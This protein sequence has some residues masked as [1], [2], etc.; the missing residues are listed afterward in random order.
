VGLTG[1]AVLGAFVTPGLF[2]GGLAAAGAPILIHLLARR[3]FKRLR[4]AAID[5][6][7]QAERK[8]RRRLRLEEWI[9][10]A[11]RCLAFILI[12]AALA[13]PFLSPDSFS[14]AL[15]GA[16]RA[17]RII[18][19]DDSM[20]MAYRADGKPVFDRAKQ[21]V[22]RLVEG[23]RRESPDDTVSLFKTSS[24]DTPIESGTFLNDAQTETLFARVE[25]LA[26]SQA[27]LDR[28]RVVSGVADFLADSPNI[29][30]AAIYVISDFQRSTWVERDADVKPEAKGAS[31]FELWREWAGDERSLFIT[32]VNVGE[33]EA[34]NSAVTAFE[35]GTGPLVA[36]T[37]SAARLRVANYSQRTLDSL[38]V[39]VFVS[40]VNQQTVALD[41]LE[42]GDEVTAD[43]ELEF[44]R[45]GSE[46]AR[47]EIPEDALTPDNTR[48]LSA[49]VSE[50]IRVLVVDGEPAPDRYDDEVTFL[51]TALRPE[52]ALASGNAPVVMDETEWEDAE[53]HEFHVVVLANVHR[54]SEPMVEQLERFVREGGGLLIFAG[55][56]TNSDLYN[57]AL[58]REGEG[59]LPVTLTEVKRPAEP[60]R[61]VVTDRLH[62][63]LRAL[64]GDGDP[65]G[66]GN[67]RFRAF[68][69]VHV[70]DGAEDAA[71]PGAVPTVDRSLSAP[72]R[73]IARF[74]DG[75]KSPAIIERR[76]GAGRVIFV[77]TSADK[78]WNDWPDHPTYLPVVMELT[79]Y[80]ARGTDS[81]D[82][83]HVGDAIQ[84]PLDPSVFESDVTVRTPSWPDEREI[85]VTPIAPKDGSDL[86]VQWDRTPDPGL[87]RFVFA[88]RDGGEEVCA[89]A[90]NVDE[91]ESD[92]AMASED[93]LSGTVGD[94]PFRYVEGLAMLSA[95]G[96]CERR[97][98]LW[99]FFLI[100][101]FIALWSEHTLAWAWG[102]R[103][104]VPAVDV[105][106][107]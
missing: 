38:S 47:I 76:L 8:N 37:P 100:A 15:R 66:V 87:Y 85:V 50:S 10:L 20:S 61:L 92:L 90:V 21:A 104:D 29:I 58:Y 89:A 97:T 98:E 28:G 102:R 11:L 9:L 88:R 94:V 41:T 46:S 59:L 83:L 13:R 45:S 72:V 12:G 44:L 63:V 69:G 19:M 75:E 25:A 99:R 18:I 36:G 77:T 2:M 62:P 32:F 84:L 82:G 70:P 71:T 107:R 106:Q 60:A 86:M 55:D 7:L 56:Q 80:V 40:G 95:D 52:G 67:I 39:G 48:Y 93:E 74:D 53:L 78:E 1:Y 64:A 27:S 68:W 96:D 31:P 22:R 79:R 23:F 3:R 65:L 91:R 35:L 34:R 42:A 43:V 105:R 33:R 24:L 54:I 26:P 81:R 5:F 16:G 51:M 49:D 73:V 6:L 17:E 4:W 14:G 101:A 57:L 30:N 103:R